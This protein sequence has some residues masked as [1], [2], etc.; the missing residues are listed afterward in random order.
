MLTCK[1]ITEM[2]THSFSSKYHENIMAEL[3]K[4]A[5]EERCPQHATE[6]YFYF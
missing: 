5:A 1:F 6:I 4:R 2:Q 3:T